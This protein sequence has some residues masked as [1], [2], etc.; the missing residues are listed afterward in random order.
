M[1]YRKPEKSPAVEV[2]FRV[3][4]TAWLN[5]WGCGVRRCRR[6]GRCLGMGRFGSPFCFRAMSDAEF[7]EMLDFVA[8]TIELATPDM[9]AQHLAQAKTDD[10]REMIAFRRSVFL[11]YHQELAKAGLAEPLGPP[12]IEG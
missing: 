6:E 12:F 10:E 4:A 3:A 2:L 11:S 5:H 1:P 9:V 7:D 8:N